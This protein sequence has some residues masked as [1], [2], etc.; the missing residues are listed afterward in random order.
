MSYRSLL[1]V[2]FLAASCAA[3]RPHNQFSL[4]SRTPRGEE[5]EFASSKDLMVSGL[6]SEALSYTKTGRLYDAESKLRQAYYV[7]PSNDRIAFNLGVIINQA[8]Q[9][10]ESLQILQKLLA[11]EPRNP[12]YLQAMADVL[13]SQ[14]R[15]DEAKDKLKEAFSLFK[16]ANNVPRA[17][18]LARSISN[19]AFGVGEEQE[20][21][22][23][24]Y[25]AVT[26]APNATQVGMHARIL[27][28]LNLF[29]QAESFVKRRKNVADQAL[30]FHALGMSRFARGNVT[31]AL[32]AEEVALDRI[33]DSPE[34][35]SEITAAWWLMKSKVPDPKAT[36]ESEERMREMRADVIDF[37]DRNPY[38]L[39]FWP[40]AL[41]RE[42]NA[43][44]RD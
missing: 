26:L 33:T 37:R 44:Q 25:E 8:G 38:E 3:P 39:V 11:K 10:E 9:S 42:L 13:V 30:A 31:D 24:S 2:A 4:S 21:L 19:I 28:A 36:E 5:V 35:S 40:S 6:V 7:E 20:A 16:G 17:A 22:C 32:E 34:L 23:Y 27:V 14:G 43:L 18:L 41:R 15:Y 29:E 1:V 12:D